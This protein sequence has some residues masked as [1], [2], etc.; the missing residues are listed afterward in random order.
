VNLAVA[1]CLILASVTQVAS[2]QSLPREASAQTLAKAASVQTASTPAVFSP[3]STPYGLTY[4]LWSA[5]WWQWALALPNDSN[6]IFPG[7]EN[8]CQNGANGQNGPVW[9]LGG[10]L[11]AAG[12]VNR[13]CAVPA[14]KA[15]FFPINTS[16]YDNFCPPTNYTVSQMRQFIKP[17]IDGTTNMSCQVD[18]V[19]VA[20]LGT[21][22][23]SPYRA[24]S[25]AFVVTYPEDNVW[26]VGPFAGCPDAHAGSTSP[27]VADGVYV[28][29]SP[30][31][32]GEHTIHYHCQPAYGD[33]LDV[34]YHL[35]VVAAQ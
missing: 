35:T 20:G 23:T 7:N 2:A 15:L 6:P 25:P 9:F 30:L 26:R 28:M 24:Q 21:G 16:E 13:T 19:S 1:L 11:N 12:T 27:A 33:A 8:T 4:S 34:T 3:T 5:A 31:S 17:N 32:E 14:G 22:T 29:V 10:V 18:G